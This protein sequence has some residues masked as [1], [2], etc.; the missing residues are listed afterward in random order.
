MSFSLTEGIPLATVH[1]A[2]PK[3]IIHVNDNDDDENM[4][5]MLTLTGNKKFQIIP[6]AESTRLAVFGPSGVGKSTFVS[7]YMREYKKKYKK[8]P[9]YIIS[10]S[11]TDKAYEGL[12]VGWIKIDDSLVSDPL[13]INEFPNSALIFDDSEILSNNK[14]IN[15]AVELF[16]NCCLENGRKLGITVVS[17]MHVAQNGM[18]S[19]KILNESE[20]VCIF[21]KSN[22][23]Q[24]ARLCKAYYG[25]DKN[26]L[27]YI[28]KLKSRWCVIRRSFPQAIVSEHE[29]KII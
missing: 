16:R 6:S 9:V 28:K 2:S 10:P 25:F 11:N 22:F 4:H 24:I 21:P 14:E 17:V 3:K 29:A 18:Q 19:K 23:S 1:G 8:N 20:I 15:K 13:D 7:D 5:K 12:N 27:D 26:E